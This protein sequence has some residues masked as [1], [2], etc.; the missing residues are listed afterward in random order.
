MKIYKIQ[1][2]LNE[3][4]TRGK[5]RGRIERYEQRNEIVVDNYQSAVQTFKDFEKKWRNQADCYDYF[6][7]VEIF[8][9]HISEHGTMMG[10]PDRENYIG[11]IVKEDGG[12]ITATHELKD[13][14]F[15]VE[16]GEE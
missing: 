5:N 9:P 10:W 16:K 8:E 7:W 4:I 11:R 6:G 1:Y 14:T 12:Q 15:F 3:R 2:V 13:E